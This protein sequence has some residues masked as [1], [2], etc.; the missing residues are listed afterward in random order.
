MGFKSF[1]NGERCLWV[2]QDEKRVS[3]Q[4]NWFVFVI[5]LTEFWQCI[6]LSCQSFNC[7]YKVMYVIELQ[8]IRLTLWLF[9]WYALPWYN[10]YGWL[11]VTHSTFFLVL[12]VA[13]TTTTKQQQQHRFHCS[14]AEKNLVTLLVVTSDWIRFQWWVP[15]SGGGEVSKHS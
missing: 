12:D 3:W 13:K 5:W 2:K 7:R 1:T 9:Y 8:C 14:P 6:D 10:R 11:G 15:A 4:W